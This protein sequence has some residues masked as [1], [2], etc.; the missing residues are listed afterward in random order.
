MGLMWCLGRDRS[1]VC[2]RYPAL[3]RGGYFAIQVLKYDIVSARL[4]DPAFV[5][6]VS[7]ALG[8]NPRMKRNLKF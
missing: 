1:C 8:V 6:C 5:V 7:K 2:G 4:I 3:R